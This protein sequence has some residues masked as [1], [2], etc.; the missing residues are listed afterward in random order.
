[1]KI[2]FP[3]HFPYEDGWLFCEKCQRFIH[4]LNNLYE[5][6]KTEYPFNRCPECDTLMRIETPSTKNEGR[7]VTN[8]G[9]G[10]P[11]W[12]YLQEFCV[13]KQGEYAID[14]FRK[15]QKHIQKNIMNADNNKKITFGQLGAMKYKKC[16]FIKNNEGDNKVE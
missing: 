11:R 5:E 8:N 15:T 14:K 4:P 6:E 3:A 7:E 10:L 1:M 16:W 9:L 12:A 2:R 13:T